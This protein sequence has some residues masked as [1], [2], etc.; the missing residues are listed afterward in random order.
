[1]KI[2]SLQT[3]HSPVEDELQALPADLLLPRII[4]TNLE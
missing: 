4:D 3:V 1:M 2:E